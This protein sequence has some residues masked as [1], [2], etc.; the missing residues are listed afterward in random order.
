MPARKRPPVAGEGVERNKKGCI[1]YDGIFVRCD[2][3]SF[4]FNFLRNG[5]NVLEN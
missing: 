4:D 3:K 2:K 1:E 5:L